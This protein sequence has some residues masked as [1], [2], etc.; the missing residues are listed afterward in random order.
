MRFSGCTRGDLVLIY[1]AG[2]PEARGDDGKLLGSD[3][4]LAQVRRVDAARPETFCHSVLDAGSAYRSG[5]PAQD[6][7]TLVVLHHNGGKPPSQ[8]IGQTVKTMSKMLGL[9]K[10]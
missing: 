1:S 10:V 4:F 8:S 3:G 7:L 2:L 6:D 9:V 5:V